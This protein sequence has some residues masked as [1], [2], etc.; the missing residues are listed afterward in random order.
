MGRRR[1]YHTP[2]ERRLA[3]NAKARRSY[4]KHKADIGAQRRKRAKKR[5]H[6]AKPQSSGV[7]ILDAHRPR[8]KPT[9]QGDRNGEND[10][11]TSSSADHQVDPADKRY[12]T[13]R[14]QRIEKNLRSL[15]GDSAI[16]FL[17]SLY[18]DYMRSRDSLPIF[19][20][21][22]YVRPLEKQI[23]ACQEQILQLYGAGD[24]W[25]AAENVRKRI[26][27]VVQSLEELELY[28]AAGD[29]VDLAALHHSKELLYQT[30][31]L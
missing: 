7:G 31:C 14:V 8:S 3:A 4:H 6:Q 20:Q 13:A 16:D 17:E 27:S 15:V 5:A 28:T 11:A 12:W 29:E 10:A 26:S 22:H 23:R 1:L 2:E 21:I 25:K 24:E 30:L 9:K 19:N 18:S